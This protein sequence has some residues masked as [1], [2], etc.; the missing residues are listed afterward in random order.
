MYFT[1]YYCNQHQQYYNHIVLQILIMIV[2][3]CIGF[4]GKVALHRIYYLFNNNKKKCP[5]QLC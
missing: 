5:M 1:S 4:H 2:F 3:N